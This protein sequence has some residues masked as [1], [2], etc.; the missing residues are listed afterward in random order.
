VKTLTAEESS[1]HTFLQDLRYGVRMLVRTPGFALIAIATLALGIGANTAIFSVV[2]ALLLRPLPY[3]NANELVMVWQDLRARG[4]PSDE[5]ATPGNFADW[6]SGGPFSATAAVQGWQPSFTGAGEPEPLVG[7]QVTRDYFDVLG[8][9]PV[10]GRTFRAEEDV[11]DAPRVVILSHGLWQRRFGGDPGVLGRSITLG[12][13]PHEIVGVMPPR[14]RPAVITVAEA[15]R[16]RRLNLANPSRGAV[17][18][19]IVARLE[20]DLTPEQASSSA[21]VLAKQLE[22]AHPESNV[23][24]GINVVPLHTEVV[25][26]IRGGL[27]VL[28]GAVGFVLLIAC[29]NIANLLLAR[30]SGRGREIAV[31]MALGAAR[32]RLV[33]QLLTESLLLAAIGGAAGV[34]VGVWGVQAL[35][36]IAPRNAPRV[37]EIGLDSTVL[38][39]TVGLTILTGVLFGL[40]PALQTTRPDVAPALKEGGRGTAGPS[41]RRARHALVVAELAVALVLLVGSGLLLRTFLRL[42]AYDLGFDPDRV[43]VG[44]VLPPRVAYPKQEQQVTFYDRLLARVSVLH[45]VETAAL[46]SILPLGGDSDMSMLIEGR[47]LPKNEAETIAVWYRLVSPGYFKA[48]RIPIKEGRNFEPGEAAPG[49]IVSEASVRRLWNGKSSLG[50]RVRFSDDANAPWFTVI[51]V[52][53]EVRMRGARGESRNE[54]YLPYWQFMELGT[55]VV[56]KT[57]GRPEALTSALRQA[58]REIDPN[59]PVSGIRSMEQIVAESIDQPRFLALLVGVFALLALTL[60]V[61]GIYGVMAFAVSHRTAEIGVRMA[62]GASHRDVFAL[63]VSDGLK[64]AAAGIFLGAVLAVG[65]SL[66]IRSLLFGVEPVDPLTFG[67]TTVALALAAATAC[68][69]PARRATRVDPIMALRTE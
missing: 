34:L 2:N 47:P 65:M 46:S 14:F 20:P 41:G 15:W 53:G 37:D 8:I 63:V 24:A 50:S 38:A 64:L 32:R 59:I 36:A 7:E 13:E 19:R 40:M 16:P 4:G 62:L 1:M 10:L 68:F 18:L 54:V 29:A 57:S 35:I 43:L 58:V 9:R 55:N 22:S 26:D 61:V 52:V 51:G 42:Q 60:A 11:P 12:G 33:K 25:G 17:V 30:A 44:S 5:W 3:P 67:A 6:K 66:T 56:L 21:S 31:R 48:L 23:G 45:G 28:L 27:L 49:I 39:F 69:V